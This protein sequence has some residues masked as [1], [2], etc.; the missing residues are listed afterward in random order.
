ML[1]KGP[2]PLL[3][4]GVVEYLIGI[5]L[6]ASPF[7]FDYGGNAKPVAIV[8][9]VAVITLAAASAGPTGLVDQVSF[10][11]HAL[12]DLVVAAILIASPFLFDF[13]DDIGPT[14]LFIVLGVG[15][16]L[17]SIGTRFLPERNEGVATI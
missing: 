10:R 8:L 17:L 3:A 12:L 14:A 4:H 7:L 9:G 16:L 13:S 2:I 5:L 11:T 6:L 15:H 1:R